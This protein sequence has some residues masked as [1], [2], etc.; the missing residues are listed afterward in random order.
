MPITCVLH[1]NIHTHIYRQCSFLFFSHAYTNMRWHHEMLQTLWVKCECQTYMHTAY[2]RIFVIVKSPWAFRDTNHYQICRNFQ[3]KNG[4]VFHCNEK[5]FTANANAIENRFSV[6]TFCQFQFSDSQSSFHYGFVLYVFHVVVVPMD[7]VLWCW[8]CV[9]TVYKTAA[10]DTH[11]YA[12]VYKCLSRRRCR[13]H[14]SSML[15][16]TKVPSL[17]HLPTSPIKNRTLV[18][19]CTTTNSYV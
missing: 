16:I 13:A 9:Y 2:T 14:H 4:I 8:C 11:I 3:P 17:T 15:S 7:W 10:A 18:M 1:N 12:Y 5:C 19:V 6:R